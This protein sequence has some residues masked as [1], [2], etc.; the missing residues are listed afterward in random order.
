MPYTNR[1]VLILFLIAQFQFVSAQNKKTVN[2]NVT[3]AKTGETLIGASVKLAGNT[4]AGTLTNAY[5]FYSLNT[6][7]GNYE[8]A[9]SFIGYKTIRQNISI[10]K[11]TRLNFAMEEDNQLNEVIIS[12]TKRN[13]NVSSPQM[14][15]QKIDVREINNVPVLL[16][17]RDILKTIQLLPGIKSA[18]EGN[19]GFYVRGGATDQNLILLDEAPVYNASHL[20]GFFSTFNSDAIKDVSVYKGGMPAQYGGRLASVLDIKMN[21]GNRKTYTAEGGI[22]LISSRLKVEGPIVKDKGSFMVSARRTYMDA[23]LSLSPDS[24]INSN[25]LFFYDLNA[26]ANYQL[27]EKNTLYLSGYFGRDKLGIADTFGFNW[28]NTTVTLRWNHL[29]SNR[30]FS[31]TS[32]IYSNYNYV[33]QNF[34][35]E[36]N[37]EV[38]SSIKDFNLKQDFEYSLSNSHNLKFGLNAIHHTIAPGKLT[39]TATSSVNE[40][41]YEDRKGLELATYISDEWT[42]SPKMNL[43]YGLR[44]SSFSLM[45]PGNIKTYDAEGNTTGTT[46]YHA[47]EFVK[48]YFNLEPRVSASYQLSNSSSLK[49]AYTR[50]VQNVHL[51]S[52]STSTSPTDLYIMNSN[53]VKPEIADQIAG[54]YFRNFNDD[55][56]EFSAEVYYKWMQNQIEYRS[57]TDLRGNANVEADL[58]YGDGRAYGLEL[59][60]KKRFG[61]FNG[62]IGYTWSRTERQ[63]DAFNNGKW[64]YAKQD[65]THDLS[66][67]GIYKASTR[68]TFSSVFVYNTGNAVTFPSG[69]YQING[70]TVFYYTEKNSYR[71]PAYHRLDVSATLEGKPGRKLQSSWSFGIYN[72]YNRQNAFSIDFKDDPDDATKTQAV[73]TTLFGIIPSVTWNFKF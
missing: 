7:E 23:L 1:I 46:T 27:D 69:K 3:D 49:A 20:L 40:T 62:W 73:R 24:N 63:F 58:L 60:F 43:V 11:D 41:R 22:G 5:G 9:V 19:S 15:L 70:R 12:A 10:A 44:L 71:T 56:Y 31:N 38:N 54:G 66:L 30:L 68:W 13:E 57:G 28:G 51:M 42:V 33:I 47:G 59:F 64:F 29:Y 67:V 61:R 14:G 32:L 65:R 36:N 45:G 39:A 53:N 50:N 6:A 8:I 25:I 16:G 52:N 72:L 21:D 26:K 35:E 18:G 55:N 34:M 4:Q 37:F 2:G 48:S 17:E